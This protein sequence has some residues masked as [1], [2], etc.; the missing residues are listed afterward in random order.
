MNWFLRSAAYLFHPLFMPLLGT[1]TYYLI[2]P[3]FIEPEFI[4]AR[5][6][7]VA[8]VT[9]FIPLITFFLL[10]NL[11]IV[12]S[13]NLTEVKERK[14]PLMIQSVLLLLII[15]MVF[16]PFDSPELYYFFVGILF[17][18]I[19]ALLMVFFR[20]KISLHQMGIAGVTMFLI[21]LSVH[22]KVNALLGI[23]VFFI[24]NGWVASSRLHTKSHIYPELIV[25]FFI[26]LLPQLILLNFWL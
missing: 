20:F 19:T 9:L 23:G 22:F 13:I 18:T 21:A 14:F 5:I 24:I 17:S 15:K 11:S 12:S 16:G 25:G 3:R 6:L 7:A 1:I 26:G 2:T 10:K 4:Q 8:I